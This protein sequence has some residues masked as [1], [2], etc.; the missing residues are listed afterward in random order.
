MMVKAMNAI[1][2]TALKFGESLMGENMIFRGGD[3]NKN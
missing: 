3:A 1:K 2:I